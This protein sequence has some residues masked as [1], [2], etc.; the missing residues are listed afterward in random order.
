MD[1]STFYAVVSA[2]CFTLVGL[3]WSAIDRRRD[4]LVATGDRRAV[5]GVYLT[6][7]VPGLMGLFAQ[8]DPGSAGVWRTTFAIAAVL[9]V[10]STLRVIQIDR[11]SVARGPFQRNRWLV[12]VLYAVIFVVGAAPGLVESLGLTALRAAG[13]S[14]VCLVALGHG[15]AW[16]LLTTVEPR[17]QPLPSPAGGSEGPTL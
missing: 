10:W 1:L 15:L 8:I 13:I 3:W 5:G 7:F 4:L 6:F 16:E 14:I 11:S 12:A 2:T 9:G 17:D